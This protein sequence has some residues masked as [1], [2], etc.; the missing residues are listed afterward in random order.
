MLQSAGDIGTKA[1]L[2]D[3][4][5][6]DL[7]AFSRIDVNTA[8]SNFV[9]PTS[10]DDYRFISYELVDRV[11][12]V[13]E[14]QEIESRE[15]G[16]IHAKLI[17]ILLDYAKIARLSLDA[18]RFAH[19]GLRPAYDGARSPVFHHLSTGEGSLDD[20]VAHWKSPFLRQSNLRARLRR[21]RRDLGLRLQS[22]VRRVD[23]M[24]R[25][26][27]LDEFAV[28]QNSQTLDLLPTQFDWAGVATL[29]AKLEARA[30]AGTGALRSLLEPRLDGNA[31]LL[32]RADQLAHFATRFHFGEAWQ[33][34]EW[35][36]RTPLLRRPARRLLTGT[37]KFRGR[38]VSWHYKRHGAEVHRFAHGGDRSFFDDYFWS[39]VELP[40]ADCYYGHGRG[41]AENVERRYREGRL[42]RLPGDATPRGVSAGSRKHETIAARARA[43]KQR[44][45]GRIVY[46][47]GGYI[48]EQFINF[49]SFHLP[50]IV[51]LDWQ[52]WLLATLRSNGYSVAAKVHP[53]GPY[54]SL[55]LLN[56]LADEIIGGHLDPNSL[57]GDCFLFDFAG[58]AF[59]DTLA[60]GAGAVY[61]DFGNRPI[62]PHVAR[63]LADRCAIVD[64]A[65]DV[66]NR[67][68]CR[69]EDLLSAVDRAS[70]FEPTSNDFFARYC[71][72]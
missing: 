19:A 39:W 60:T 61:C 64:V 22:P 54:A 1:S 41:E 40:F 57:E 20:I 6:I 37:P 68:R 59:F 13:L 18:A 25:N 38:L 21:L 47:P 55:S 2:S 36:E 27:L 29:P 15:A 72:A 31:A 63:D 51:F 16:A 43:P 56:D 12:D 11:C 71:Q 14:V 10:P 46:V 7:S 42:R 65:A 53:K 49:P 66:R 8:M 33:Y 35:I 9:W 58:T 5:P 67:M 52:R 62:D 30:R 24:N 3:V 28:A 4:V 69:P 34:L 50:D 44:D 70:R 17:D 26:I 23:V 48:D 45:T 32:E